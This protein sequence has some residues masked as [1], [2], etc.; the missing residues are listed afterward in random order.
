MRIDLGWRSPGV[1]ELTEGVDRTLR[2][3]ARVVLVIVLFALTVDALRGGVPRDPEGDFTDEI[4]TPLQFSLLALVAFGL[5]V[6][7]RSMALAAAI[8]ALGGSALGVLSTLEYAPPFG[9]FVLV[10]FLVPAV[11]MWL[12]WQHRETPAKILVLAVST[13]SLLS[14]AWFAGTA[15]YTWF[16]GPFHPQSDTEPLADSPV[17]WLWSGAVDTDGFTVTARLRE[18]AGS[19]RLVVSDESGDPITTSATTSVTNA[20]L[21][22][23]LVVRGLDPATEY[24]YAVEIDGVPDETRS[25]QARTFPAGSG[26]FT[27]AVAAC[28]NNGSNGEVFDTIRELDPDLYVV[29]GDLHYRNITENALDQFVDAFAEVHGQ[30]AQSALYR[31]VPMAYIWDDHDFGANNADATSPARPA[32]WA[33][34][35]S[36]VPHYNLPSGEEGSIH[37]AFTIGRVRFVMTDSRSMR[38]P[39]DETLLGDEQLEW[40]LD[41]LLAARDTHALTVWVSSTPWI[42]EADPSS[43]LWGGF[44]DERNRIGVFLAEHEIT[45]LVMVAGDAHMVAIDDGSN[46]G[47]GGSQGFPVLQ[48]AALDRPGSVKGGPYSHGTFPGGGQ[49]GLID[50]VDDGGDHVEVTL[51]GLDYTGDELLRLTVDFA[52]PPTRS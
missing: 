8:V 36:H 24:T 16:N 33:S 21:P 15:V 26:S 11:L 46:S 3:A 1:I 52:A 37:Q 23:S 41:E 45:N 32:A 44:A 28:A 22:V 43:D 20:D 7:F 6:S 27:V 29:S 9:F 34:Y 5:A 40:L 38:Q 10:A 4:W 18:P 17:R 51:R 13:A 42:S 2:I 50:V 47:Y 39:A 14:G 12:A 31:A 49:F 35:R 25:G 30:P 19:V 48:A